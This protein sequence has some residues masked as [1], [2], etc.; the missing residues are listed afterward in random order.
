MV[1]RQ[2]AAIRRELEQTREEHSLKNQQMEEEY[3]TRMQRISAEQ[4][5]RIDRM[6]EQFAKMSA[7]EVA[8]RSEE[9]AKIL[10]NNRSLKA[11]SD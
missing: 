7:D 3:V 2:V 4:Q 8:S 11:F 9:M 5:A 1:F 6:K 10:V